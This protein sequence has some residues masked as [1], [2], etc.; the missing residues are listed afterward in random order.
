MFHVELVREKLININQIIKIYRIKIEFPDN[1]IKLT[2]IT[3]R[4]KQN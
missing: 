3:K 2:N 4:M 1:R